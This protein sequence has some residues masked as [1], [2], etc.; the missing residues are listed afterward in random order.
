MQGVDGDVQLHFQH[1]GLSDP[2]T[3]G[4]PRIARQQRQSIS[5]STTSPPYLAAPETAIGVGSTRVSSVNAHHVSFGTALY[6]P[7]MTTDSK[8]VAEP[9]ESSLPAT[10]HTA[11]QQEFA[12][13]IRAPYETF[14]TVAVNGAVMS[15]A[16]FFLPKGLKD[17][18]FT[19]HGTL[20]F[21]LVLAAWMYSDVPATNVL[22]PDADRVAAALD[23]PIMFRRLLYGKNIVLWSLI[24]PV[25]IVVALVNGIFSH[26]LLATLYSVIWIGVV[27]FGALGISGVVGIRFPYH[28]MPLRFRWE[29]RVPRRRMLWRW[30]AL[31]VTPYGLVPLLGVV[32]MLPSLL[33]WGLT[34]THGLA[35]KLPDHDLGWG[36]ALACVVAAVCSF[37]GHRFGAWL[38]HRRRD[39]LGTFLADPTQG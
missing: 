6:R 37:G 17:K 14:I 13:A 27:P 9:S 1:V 28:P 11:V 18:V 26:N 10:L 22:G 16:W 30:L 34:S 32:I 36:V 38:A 35:Q 24:T 19:L 33:L 8:P 4:Y 12:R 2:A 29:H 20:A 5:I 25:C 7:G 15:S 3:S 21:A 23:D 39:A 31:V